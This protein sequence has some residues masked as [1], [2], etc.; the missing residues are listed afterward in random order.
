MPHQARGRSRFP[1]GVA[2]AIVGLFA[3]SSAAVAQMQANPA[4]QSAKPDAATFQLGGLIVTS[5]QVWAMPAGDK[6]ASGY[7]KISNNG[8]APDR[9]VG[10]TSDMAGRVDIRQVSMNDG[11]VKV[12]SP[13]DGIEI[14]P[15]ETV[16]LQSGGYH[17]LFRH[18]KW[19]LASCVPF[20]ATLLFE[21]AGR[22]E[23]NFSVHGATG[24]G[25]Y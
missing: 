23:V 7:L 21:N 12:R 5:L 14:K 16:E 17:L 11:V 8:T 10:A 24:C 9:F 1:L 15:G 18:L 3:I 22:L 20:T 4:R 13:P 25:V 19:A 2:I 6:V